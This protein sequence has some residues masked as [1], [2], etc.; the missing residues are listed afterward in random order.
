MK[1]LEILI[2]PPDWLAVILILIG[3][4]AYLGALILLKNLLH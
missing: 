3:A 4:A 2:T 1:L